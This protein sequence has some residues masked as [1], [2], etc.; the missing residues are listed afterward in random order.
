MR[1]KLHRMFRSECEHEDTLVV[2]SV[3]VHRFVCESCGHISFQISPDLGKTRRALARA[4]LRKA[5]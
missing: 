5:G 4:S 1:R 2:S 3:G